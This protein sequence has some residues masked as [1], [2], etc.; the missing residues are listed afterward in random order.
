M[1]ISLIW[2]ENLLFLSWLAFFCITRRTMVLDLSL[3]LSIATYLFFILIQLG[4]VN[5]LGFL[6]FFLLPLLLK[7][8]LS[9]L[10]LIFHGLF[11]HLND[12]FIN[13]YDF[14]SIKFL[15]T[16]LSSFVKDLTLNKMNNLIPLLLFL[17]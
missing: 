1:L 17:R 5:F 9:V 3:W 7:L 11:N 16:E 13:F 12:Y 4:F 10:L 14:L 15:E 2:L 6:H 8:I